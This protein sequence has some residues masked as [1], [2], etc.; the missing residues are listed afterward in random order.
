M[1]WKLSDI[2]NKMEKNTIAKQQELFEPKSETSFRTITLRLECM[3]EKG[4]LLDPIPKQGDRAK[5]LPIKFANPYDFKGSKYY[6]LDQLFVSHYTS[7]LI[8]RWEKH[9]QWQIKAQLPRD[10]KMFE[11]EVHVQTIEF[12]FQ[13]LKSMSK[14]VL[15]SIREGEIIFKTTKPDLQDNLVKP[16][17]DALEGIVLKHDAIV[18]SEGQKIKRYGMVPGINIE[19]SGM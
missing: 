14:K 19:L 2:K 7:S 8:T 18:C 3:R 17:Y 9:L 16:L 15:A 13:P 5:I 4:V 6:R 10:F 11:K 1:N 12:I